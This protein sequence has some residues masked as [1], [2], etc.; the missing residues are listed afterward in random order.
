[1]LTYG[2][3]RLVECFA[4]WP[5]SALDFTRDNSAKATNRFIRECNFATGFP[6][7]GI[8]HSGETIWILGHFQIRPSSNSSHS[9]SSSEVKWG[10]RA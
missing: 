4:G 9:A 10:K 1:M 8:W 5:R 3:K 6:Q 2:P 7:Q